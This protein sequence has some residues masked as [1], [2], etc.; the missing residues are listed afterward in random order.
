MVRVNAKLTFTNHDQQA[1]GAV[2]LNSKQINLEDKDCTLRDGTKVACLP[3]NLCMEYDGVGADD[4]IGKTCL[5]L[6]GKYF[7]VVHV[8]VNVTNYM[9]VTKVPELILI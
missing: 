9:E 3:L 4:T 5:T 2:D 7:L 8:N 1:A 6:Q